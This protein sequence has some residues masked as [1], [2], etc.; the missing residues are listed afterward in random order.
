MIPSCTD[1]LRW[2]KNTRN[3]NSED[4]KVESDTFN[5]FIDA[6]AGAAPVSNMPAARYIT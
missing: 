3:N 6:A 4:K 5:L 2:Q 1:A